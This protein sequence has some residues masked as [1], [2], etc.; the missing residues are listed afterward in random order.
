MA[1]RQ[2]SSMLFSLLS[3]PQGQT[4]LFSW[5]LP[6]CTHWQAIPLGVLVSL[7]NNCYRFLF[8]ALS[9]VENR[10][11]MKDQHVNQGISCLGWGHPEQCVHR[12]SCSNGSPGWATTF[13]NFSFPT[14][15]VE[16][17]ILF[18]KPHFLPPFLSQGWDSGVFMRLTQW[19]YVKICY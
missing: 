11:T 3:E 5:G 6:S 18:T 16:S 2:G 7:V 4:S 8:L 13:L 10:L 14:W 12:D 19:F 17:R 1:H 9:F 15:Q